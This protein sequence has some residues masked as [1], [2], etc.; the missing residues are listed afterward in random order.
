MTDGDT[1][2]IDLELLREQIEEHYEPAPDDDGWY[3]C[4]REGE[5]GQCNMKVYF[6]PDRPGDLASHEREHGALVEG[7][8]DSMETSESGS[9]GSPRSRS[10]P[11]ND[12]E[13]DQSDS[14]GTSDGR[15]DSA[16]RNR[17]PSR[18]ELIG[19]L[20]RLGEQIG[21]VPST[22]DLKEHGEYSYN[23]Y[24]A[25]FDSW[26]DALAAS[27]WDVR[28]ELADTI[29]DVAQ[30]K[31]GV[32]PSAVVEAGPYPRNWY[33]TWFDD[34]DDALAAAG[35]ENPDE[36]ELRSVLRELDAD[37]DRF[38]TR[39][40]VREMGYLA[41]IFEFV[42]DSWEEALNAAGIDREQRLKRDFERVS[43]RVRGTPAPSD[44]KRH[45]K[46]SI[47][48][49]EAVFGWWE[50]AVDACE[51]ETVSHGE[52]LAGRGE[53]SDQSTGQSEGD[54]G[55]EADRDRETLL[56]KLHAVGDEL[57]RIP[58]STDLG[59]HGELS[60]SPYYAEFG[61]WQETLE[62]SDWDVR[63][64]LADDIRRVAD[65]E[66]RSI[67]PRH[68]IDEGAYPRDWYENWFDDW[69]AGFEAA[70][71]E[72]PTTDELRDALQRIDG[73]FDRFPVRRDIEA[74]DFSHEWY[75]WTFGSWEEA[76]EAVGIDRRAE[77][78]A[79]VRAVAEVVGGR[80]RPAD[81]ET[82]GRYPRALYS[83][84]FVS[85]R[86]AIDTADRWGLSSSEETAAPS[87]DD[88]L[89]GHPTVPLVELDG[90]DRRL[91]TGSSAGDAESDDRR[92]G[93]PDFS[94]IDR[95]GDRTEI[96]AEDFRA[97]H[98][99]ASERDGPVSRAA[100][101]DSDAV[102]A[103]ELVDEYGSLAQACLLAGV[104][105]STGETPDPTLPGERGSHP[106]TERLLSDLRAAV[107]EDGEKDDHVWDGD[108]I[109]EFRYR[110]A[111]GS[112]PAA[113]LEVGIAWSDVPIIGSFEEQLE[114]IRSLTDELGRPPTQA[115]QR[116]HAVQLDLV[117][118]AFA[119]VTD[120]F[121]AVGLDPADGDRVAELARHVEALADLLEHRPNRTEFDAYLD[122]SG[123]IV[124]E[125]RDAFGRALERADVPDE[126]DLTPARS[127]N[128]QRADIHDRLVPSHTDLF[129]E[130]HF[131]TRQ[132]P[133]LSAAEAVR[134]HG[135]IDEW[136]YDV[137]FGSLAAGIDR[138]E[139]LDTISL[140]RSND[141]SPRTPS[142]ELTAAV[143]ELA[144]ILGRRPLPAEFMQLGEADIESLT[145][146]FDSWADVSDAATPVTP[147]SNQELL[148][149]LVAVGRELGYPPRLEEFETLGDAPV[150]CY[151]RRFG[152]WPQA[153]S[154]VGVDTSGAV[155]EDY[156]A[157]HE[158][159]EL[160][161]YTDDLLV[162]EF[163]VRDA[164]FDELF[165]LQYALDGRPTDAEV[166]EYSPYSIAEY[167]AEFGSVDAA[168]REA[169]IESEGRGG[170]SRQPSTD[171]LAAE[172]RRSVEETQKWVV[173]QTVCEHTDLTPGTLLGAFGSW[174]AAL[175]AAHLPT[176]HFSGR[177]ETYG[178]V[179]RQ[180]HQ[181]KAGILRSIRQFESRHGEV[182]T[183]NEFE[184][185]QGISSNVVYE[186]FDTWDDALE[187]AG[188]QGTEWTPT[189]DV[190]DTDLGNPD[191]VDEL[192]DDMSDHIEG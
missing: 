187:A 1:D 178:E 27:D 41:A 138:F 133:G 6:S 59:D 168:V 143:E 2:E 81:V 189:I 156:L 92:A 152:T 147:Y 87:E 99:L 42:F 80:P 192:L 176:D 86:H 183:L 141:Y 69:S 150:V 172:L 123:F 118:Q 45:G 90:R 180:S 144:E 50:A 29:D 161:S 82:Y 74:L 91:E 73:L 117:N 94:N 103:D 173:P 76:L 163:G 83:E 77:L 188:T 155:P 64:E 30:G 63:A 179:W 75:E 56:E 148:D 89:D 128:N 153:L 10:D 24:Y 126:R 165:R 110:T 85:L 135:V 4:Q 61:G 111:L 134:E 102:V 58:R 137:Q 162:A 33:K 139:S 108:E 171:E 95:I 145:F 177:S 31:R 37:L 43:D 175:D 68:V 3:L 185:V 8:R 113:L 97:L 114:R 57:G 38:P 84:V 170:R 19:E 125:G 66:D 104:R 157:Y 159:A 121:G 88:R 53:V 105:Y 140:A 39:E 48:E 12:S 25:E 181:I 186:Y 182:P 184:A 36:A 151:I 131:A 65:R 55:P 107:T 154:L 190:E 120:A 164:L 122:T 62:A 13:R 112:L 23:H 101:V 96:R 132:Q 158:T 174:E 136:H 26:R 35:V 169:G 93:T 5:R 129:V 17:S 142:V 149:E 115:F 14:E 15:E 32:T 191:F 20:H 18:A 98:R 22:T 47:Q 28:A 100:V 124:G 70:G 11:S 67:T 160:W 106:V 119:D 166:R 46:Y 116:N 44:V 130:I 71:V 54:T 146:G 34:W 51:R 16:G 167:E 78:E 7:G 127:L 109:E 9:D 79:D 52:A 40:D 49:Y 72:Y 21:H 60:Y